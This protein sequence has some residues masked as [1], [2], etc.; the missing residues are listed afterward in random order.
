MFAF[1]L[2]FVVFSVAC[3]FVSPRPP[4]VVPVS[5][6]V[7]LVVASPV[8]GCVVVGSVRLRRRL[9]RRVVF[10]RVVLRSRSGRRLSGA[11]FAARLRVVAA[12]RV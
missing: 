12:R 8:R 3:L 2:W 4:V 10:G 9:S 11:A 5:R 7:A 6:S 1:V